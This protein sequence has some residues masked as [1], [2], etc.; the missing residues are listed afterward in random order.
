M[1]TR[2]GAAALGHET[3]Q[4]AA[5]KKA[6]LIIDGKVVMRGRQVT[7]VSERQVPAEASKALAR[8]AGAIGW[9]R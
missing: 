5:G 3:G 6:D 4:L 7:T 1:A 8:V 9:G 2:T